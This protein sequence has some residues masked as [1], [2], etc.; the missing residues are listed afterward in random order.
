MLKFIGTGDL[1]NPTLGN[2]CAYIKQGKD[3]LLLDCGT[4]AFARMQQLN[5]F[6][7]VNNINIAITHMHPDHVG[8][9][10]NTIFYLNYWKNIVPNILVPS[11][12]ENSHEDQLKKLLS[13]QGIG[14]SNYKFITETQLYVNGVSS[15]EFKTIE[16]SE[17]IKCFAFEI[18]FQN[19][20][21]YYLGDNNDKKYLK[22]IIKKLQKDDLIYTDCTTLKLKKQVHMLLDVLNQLADEEIRKQIF[23]MHFCSDEDIEE[24]KKSG[25]S[26]AR[27]E[28]SKQEYLKI[29]KS[30]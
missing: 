29:I 9:L 27:N 17:N 12:S 13:V 3:L 16:H 11:A 30:R 7:D 20:K 21:I 2:T 14:D 1:A 25:Y 24:I 28:Q 26:I 19:K 10:A 4:T 5:I 18:V 22:S 23:C 15:F 8:G 6:D